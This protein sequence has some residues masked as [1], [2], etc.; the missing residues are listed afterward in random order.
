MMGIQLALYK[1]QGDIGNAMIR[2]W[3]Q[4]IY[5]HTELVV[6][7]WCY[8][9]SVMDKGVRKKRVGLGDD[10]IS[11]SPDKWDL[12]DLPWAD[13]VRVVEFFRATDH[14]RYGWPTLLASQV[15][16]RNLQMPELAFC[17][18]W[19]AAALGLP[20]PASYSPAML[21][22]TCRWLNEPTFVAGFL[23]WHTLA[24]A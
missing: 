23:A 17:S 8:S 16:N 10:E 12:I 20:C 24:L 15:F 6:D 19:D 1:G 4:S 22:A 13:P 21:G 3:T 9:S 11:L 5:S 14:Y 7:G 2:W 18:E